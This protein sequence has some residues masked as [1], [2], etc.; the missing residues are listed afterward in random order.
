MRENGCKKSC[1]LETKASKGTKPGD[2]VRVQPYITQ[3][4]FYSQKLV[5]KAN[6]RESIL[7]ST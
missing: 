2:L 6:K 5:G 3:L 4:L 1:G 7:N